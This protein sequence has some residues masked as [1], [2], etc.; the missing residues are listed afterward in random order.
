M[1]APASVS[2][3]C[4]FVVSGPS[5]V[6]KTVLCNRMIE[7]FAPALVY[8][9]SATTRAPRGAEKHGVE[10]FFYTEA[11]FKEAIARDRLAEWA[12]VHGH[13]YGTPKAFLDDNRRAGRHILLNIDVQGGM[14]IK[15]AYPEAVLIFLQA[16]SFAVLEE[17][18]RR[19]N[20]D[21]EETVRQRLANAKVEMTFQGRYDVSIIND[22]LDR[23]SDELEGIIRKRIQSRS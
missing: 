15:A 22:H 3:G 5:G 23:A 13:Y 11:E 1:N 8:S 20:M 10:Y 18:I 2:L 21:A 4:L 19:R 9:I 6:G 16:P 14:K 17:R 12:L 7:R